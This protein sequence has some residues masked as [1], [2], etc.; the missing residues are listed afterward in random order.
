M[1]AVKLGGRLFVIAA[2]T[3]KFVCDGDEMGLSTEA[4]IYAELKGKRVDEA[5][6]GQWNGARDRG[7]R[8]T[9]A[10]PKVESCPSAKRTATVA[11]LLG[12]PRNERMTYGTA[13]AIFPSLP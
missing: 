12:V 11:N 9:A 3:G 6:L 8:P 2:S 7:G 5:D 1:A 13:W 4:P 10:T